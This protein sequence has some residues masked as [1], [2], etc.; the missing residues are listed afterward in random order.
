MYLFSFHIHAIYTIIILQT[1]ITSQLN[2]LNMKF[3]SNEDIAIGVENLKSAI[4]FYED[5]LGFEP[6][7]SEPG[8]RVYKTGHFTLYIKEGKSHP[9]VPSFTVKKLS[10]A[11]KHLISK[12]CIILNEQDK[13]LYFRDPTGVI[14][15][16]IEA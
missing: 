1:I 9:P 4:E 8:L 16:I 15:D 2:I 12:R 7:K 11:K 10:R 3:L 13:S 5:T 6:I 14:W